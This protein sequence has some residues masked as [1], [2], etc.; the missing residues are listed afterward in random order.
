V[1]NSIKEES[2]LDWKAGYGSISIDGT[3]RK[4]DAEGR[5]IV[6][7]GSYVVVIQTTVKLV[8]R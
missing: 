6:K 2:T 3:P 7:A 4:T 8:K 5:E 1:F